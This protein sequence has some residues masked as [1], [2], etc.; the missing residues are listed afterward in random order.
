MTA[1]GGA[2]ASPLRVGDPTLHAHPSLLCRTP[3]LAD[4]LQVAT[5]R[6]LG[7]RWPAE[8]DP[9][10]R[11]DSVQRAWATRSE[12]LLPLA[13]RDG[14]VCL[15]PIRSE[16]SAADRLRELLQCAFGPQW[17]PDFE[18]KL[19]AAA[20][21]PEAE[22]EATL[23]DWLRDAFFA[24]HCKRFHDRPFVWHV[25]DGRK[26]GFHALVHYHKLAGPAGEG[27]R[28]L[29]LLAFTYLNDWIERQRAD[30]KSGLEGSDGRL[31]AALRLQDELKKILA[32]EPPY[33][34]FVRWKPLHQQPLGWD[35]DIHDGV[36]LNI[37]PF[38]LAADM[39]AKDAG[40]LRS[41]VGVEWKKEVKKWKSDR[42]KEPEQL[43]PCAQF[44]WFWSCDP[45][46]PQHRT[47]YL[48]AKHA[49][50]DGV[51]W[52]DLHYSRAVKDAARKQREAG[53]G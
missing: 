21:G 45:E 37:R 27:R 26:D 38:L 41:K 52:N 9:S 14:I 25:W 6:L 1:S 51:R 22:P 40:V 35:P 4:V 39:K 7:Y 28:T 15:H 18:P 24:E 46:N 3:N 49:A 48:A 11:L 43:R 34:L 36:R 53:G 31:T 8:L 19:L 17:R 29:E 23:E 44:P 20:A 2:D 10:M 50:F 16:A 32:G 30:I 12:E 42:G 5:A 13:D 33:D 47:D